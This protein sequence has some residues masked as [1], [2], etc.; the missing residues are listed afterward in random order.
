MPK[1]WQLMK[2]LEYVRFYSHHVPLDDSKRTFRDYAEITSHTLTFLVTSS[3]DM[4]AEMYDSSIPKSPLDVKIQGGHVGNSSVNSIATI[5]TKD[6]QRLLSNVNQAVFVDK[7]TR[8][9]KAIPDWWKEKY[10]ESA[11]NYE[12]LKFSK[13]KRPEGVMPF[14]I[15][16][17]RSDIDANNHVNWTCYVRY[18]L[19]GLYHNVK[20]KLI[21]GLDDFEKRGLKR[22]E[23]LFSGESFDDDVLDVFVWADLEE[24]L[25]AHVHIEK[26][27]NFLFQGSFKFQEKCQV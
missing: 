8:R 24:E 10:A 3:F 12:S 15:H 26:N 7:A 23:L 5:Y 21:N 25:R 19:D 4:D 22:M 14:K 1:P 6:G 13:I 9:P 20:H 11:K 27:S 17:V 16:V 2:F 18:A